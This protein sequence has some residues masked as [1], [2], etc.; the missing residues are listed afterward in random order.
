MKYI[1]TFYFLPILN[2]KSECENGQRNNGIY[3]NDTGI[4]L[5]SQVVKIIFHFFFNVRYL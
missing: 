1:P 2:V 4:G 3:K 5:E